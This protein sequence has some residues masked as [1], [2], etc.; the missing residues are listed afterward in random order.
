M[1]ASWA[2]STGGSREAWMARD[3][4]LVMAEVRWR[5]GAA[6]AQERA[7]SKGAR[8]PFVRIIWIVEWMGWDWIGLEGG[9][10]S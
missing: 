1:M 9:T 7:A 6:E 8:V 2:L 3:T 5:R 4:V 10:S